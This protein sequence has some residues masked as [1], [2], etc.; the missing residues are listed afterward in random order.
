MKQNLYVGLVH[1]PVYNKFNE[2]VTTSITNLD[3][4]DISRSCLTFGVKKFF[5]INPLE[6]QEIFLK[7]ILK[8]WKSEIATSYNPDRV[9]A[10]SLIEYAKDIESVIKKINQQEEDCLMITTTATDFKDQLGFEDLSKINKPVLLLFGTGS[11]LTKEV[12]ELADYILKPI[13]G[14]GN[15]NHLSARSAV[16]IVLDRLYSEK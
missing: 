12:H 5:I 15:Y 1:H 10:L 3:V 7:R 16:A 6:T 13:K 14:I 8:F 2:V 9:I 4:H 11:G